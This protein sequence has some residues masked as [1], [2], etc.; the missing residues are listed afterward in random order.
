MERKELIDKIAYYASFFVSWIKGQAAMNS[1]DLNVHAE[2]AFIPILDRVF[3]L[4]LINANQLKI[5]HPAIDLID[6][7]KGVAFQLTATTTGEKVVDTLKKFVDNDLHKTYSTLYIFILTEKSTKYNTAKINNITNGKFNFDIEKHII[8]YRDILRKIHFLNTVDTLRTIAVFYEQLAASQFVITAQKQQKKLRDRIGK[9][10][11]FTEHIK[12]ELRAAIGEENIVKVPEIPELFKKVELLNTQL[13]Q[14]KKELEDCKKALAIAS[15]NAIVSGI[16]IKAYKNVQEEYKDLN[17]VLTQT[18]EM[19]EVL[20]QRVKRQKDFLDKIDRKQ[21]SAII[22]KVKDLFDKG[23]YA[24]VN[25]LL[26]YEGRQSYIQKKLEEKEKQSVEWVH[27]AAEEVF[28]ALNLLQSEEWRQHI[29]QITTH[30][31]QSIE[32]G[33]YGFN[34][35]E[36]SFFLEDINQKEEATDIIK[37][38]ITQLPEEEIENRGLVW[39][40]LG[41]L[42]SSSDD[43]EALKAY[44]EAAIIYERLFEREP[45]NYLIPLADA[46]YRCG[47]I[48]LH[49]SL[50]QAR[51]YLERALMLLGSIEKG[52]ALTLRMT[53]FTVHTLGYMHQQ[54]NDIQQTSS[55]LILLLE[56]G[57]MLAME[58]P[59]E[60]VEYLMVAVNTFRK[61]SGEGKES[62]HT[63][64]FY[65]RALNYF[66]KF[67]KELSLE[68]NHQYARNLIRVGLRLL[69]AQETT[70]AELCFRNALKTFRKV[71]KSGYPALT[72]ISDALSWVGFVYMTQNNVKARK[73]VL[74]EA[75]NI[76]K[77]LAE[78]NPIENL[79]KAAFLLD[80]LYIN[81]FIA[82]SP[83]QFYRA[84]PF[85]EEALE[86]YKCLDK[87]YNLPDI[88]GWKQLLQHKA[89]MLSRDMDKSD[90]ILF[91]Q[92]LI[93][94]KD[95]IA[96]LQPESVDEWLQSVL[97]ELGELLLK[98]VSVEHPLFDQIVQDIITARTTLFAED[99]ETYR[100]YLSLAL[101]LAGEELLKTEQKENACAH[102]DRGIVLMK[103]LAEKEPL[104]YK[105]ILMSFMFKLAFG[106]IEIKKYSKAVVYFIDLCNYFESRLKQHPED[107]TILVSFMLSTAELLI[108]SGEK[109]RAI[110]YISK[111]RSYL[112]SIPE[113]SEQT[114]LE[115]S[116]DKL[117][118][119][120]HF[121][122]K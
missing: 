116:F 59:D 94:L 56:I 117:I 112:P 57:G 65:Q 100:K 10:M 40:R 45:E 62:Q 83:S 88:N 72:D 47:S 69:A 78:E 9:S 113:T 16:L 36:Y 115:K 46:V 2:N 108:F 13:S 61:V 41:N 53:F 5:N 3:D 11:S 17:Q 119:E 30:F 90:V 55:Y 86:I 60:E 31:E 64:L 118:N 28:V 73:K 6:G 49:T 15:A 105:E 50:E 4:K 22:K 74:L 7:E 44:K 71:E 39:S 110:D 33:G 52:N 89:A 75:L 63:S 38:V 93:S 12:E 120:H 76:R 114:R 106:Y 96:V 111:A 104:V 79:S 92:E 84:N 97:H 32:F 70:G 54:R 67:H 122:L 103:E 109:E 98:S 51:G 19:I 68:E 18:K 21:A 91:Y 101:L 81:S 99:A 35:Y 77:K 87:N 58:N 8:D 26:N 82:V 121:K 23:E 66:L 27:L 37:K 42:L 29:P 95:R 85:F 102:L 25:E 14:K 20:I 107:L 24:A 1:Y 34:A 80:E 43:E 48:L